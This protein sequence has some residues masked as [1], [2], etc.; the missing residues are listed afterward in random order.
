MSQSVYNQQTKTMTE[1]QF[2][3][4]VDAILAGKYSW[5]C[6][7]ILQTAGYNPLHYMPYRTYNRLIKD[8]C[9]QHQ[10]SSNQQQNHQNPEAKSQNKTN[11]I[12]DISYLETVDCQASTIGGGL[13]SSWFSR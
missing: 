11:K 12:K 13:R 5:A 9:L 8:N 10:N 7:L 3:K 1:Q 6:V 4:I 2:E